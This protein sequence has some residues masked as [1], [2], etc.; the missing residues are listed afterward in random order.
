MSESTTHLALQNTDKVIV[1][2]VRCEKVGSREAQIIETDLR[3]AAP[4]RKWRM[5]IDLTDVTLL[6]SMGLGMLVTL[7]K[8]AGNNGGKLAICGLQ[9]D[10]VQLLKVTHLERVLKI[11]PDRDAALKAVS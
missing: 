8:E 5:V 1:A 9:P 10:I 11:H 4:E 3:K 6:A 7:H 2:L